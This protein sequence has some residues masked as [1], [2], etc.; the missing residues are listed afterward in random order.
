LAVLTFLVLLFLSVSGVCLVGDLF[1]FFVQVAGLLPL[2][3]IFFGSFFAYAGT[4]PLTDLATNFL[5]RL[6][7]FFALPACLVPLFFSVHS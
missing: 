7:P 5:E 1:R 4:L 2:S 3:A 6:A